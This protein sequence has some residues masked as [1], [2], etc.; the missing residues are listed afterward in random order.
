MDFFGVK[1]SSLE[2][3]QLGIVDANLK[4]M[5]FVFPQVLFAQYSSL[6]LAS[7]KILENAPFVTHNKASV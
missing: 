4:V 5:V 7:H 1:G 3:A 6:M 2:R